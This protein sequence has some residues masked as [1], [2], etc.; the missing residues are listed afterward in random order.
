MKPIR[1]LIANALQRLADKIR[2]LPAPGPKPLG[3]GGGHAE[4]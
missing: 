1:T 2:P 3:G 4:E